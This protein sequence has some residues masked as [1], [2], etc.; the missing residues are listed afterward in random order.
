M[1]IFSPKTAHISQMIHD[2]ER[3]QLRL[4]L[5]YG[6]EASIFGLRAF[7]AGVGFCSTSF[8]VNSFY[9]SPCVDS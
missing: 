2:P 8:Y 1:Q 6:R 7:E 3:F 4:W 5:Y 9:Y